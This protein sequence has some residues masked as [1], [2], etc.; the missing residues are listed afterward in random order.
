VVLNT[1][2]TIADQNTEQGNS[3]R[4]HAFTPVGVRCYAKQD[5]FSAL[6]AAEIMMNSGVGG[7]NKFELKRYL[8]SKDFKGSVLPY[9]DYDESGIRGVTSLEDLETALQLIYLYFTSPNKDILAFE[10]W[11]L[12]ANSFYALE[13]INENDFRTRIRTILGDYTF[14]PEGTKAL[15]G[16]SKTDMDRALA[17]FNEIYGNAEDFTFIF[18]GSFSENKVLALSQKYLGNLPVKPVQKPCNH[19]TTK[20]NRLPKPQKITIP[21]TEYMQEAKV[22]LKYISSL[23][24]KDLNWKEEA[25]LQLLQYL[26]NFSIMQEMRFKSEEEGSYN[27]SIWINRDKSRLFNEV[28]L[29]FTSNP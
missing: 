12:K 10:D 28:S 6:N 22:Q 11:K 7:L 25:K 21:S 26:M 2:D 24:S 13:S 1:L 4:L 8:G 16:V 15:E 14:L 23:T 19:L 27:I 20:H 9:I 5:Y 3:I 29:Q 17:I 18:T